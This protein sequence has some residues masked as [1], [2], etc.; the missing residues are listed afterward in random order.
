MASS[1]VLGRG[2][3]GLW[4]GVAAG[5]TGVVR[6]PMQGYSDGTGVMAGVASSLHLLNTFSTQVASSCSVSLYLTSAA[7]TLVYVC[8]SK[9]QGLPTSR[10]II[11]AAHT[12]T[13]QCTKH[14]RSCKHA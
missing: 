4:G 6:T 11:H 14:T 2:V 13:G 1:G 3:Q 9:P 10:C 7:Q 8:C 12:G 5:V